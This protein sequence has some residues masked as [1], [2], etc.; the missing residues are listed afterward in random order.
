MNMLAWTSGLMIIVCLLGL[1]AAAEVVRRDQNQL[2]EW[3]FVSV[4]AHQDP[5]NQVQLDAIFTTPSGAELRVPGFWAGGK[6]WRVR[7]A[8]PEV[9]MHRFRTVWSDAA[10]AGLHGVEGA[11]EITKYTGDNPLYRRGP[12]RVSANKRYFE[13]ADGTP[14]FWLGDTWWLGL[15]K[16]LRFP[17]EFDILAKDRVA[18][19][20]TVVQIVAGLY[21]DMPAFDPRGQNEAGFPWEKDYARINPAYFDEADM[22]IERLVD[23]GLSP[24]IVGAWGFHLPWLGVEKMKRHWRYLIARWGAYPVFWCAAGEGMMP[25]Y[26]STERAK[27][28]ELQ[29]RGWTE[30]CA[31]I[32]ATDPYRRP[33][34]I[35][36]IDMARRQVADA[37]VLDF[38]ML[39]TGHS[40]RA[41]IAPTIQLLRESR[42]AKPTMPTLNSEV[43]YEG[44][45]GRH[46]E[47]IQ[48]IMA[49][50]SLLAGTAGHTYGGNGIWQVN[51]KGDEFGDSAQGFNWGTTPWDDAM[52]LP[53]STQVGHAKKL[54]E[55][56]ERWRFE[57]HPEWA[58][59]ETQPN[60]DDPPMA[61][62]QWIWHAADGD[63]KHEAPVGRR[64]F[65]RSFDLA[66]DAKVTSAIIRLSAD[67]RFTLIVNG[68][69]LATQTGWQRPR[70]FDIARLL[71]PGP[72]T[73]TIEAENVKSHVPNNPA[74]FIC[75]GEVTLE[76]S[77]RISLASDASW[78]SSES[79]DGD[80]KAA[81]VLAPYGAKPWGEL[82]AADPDVPPAAAGIPHQVRIIYLA[83][84]QPVRVANLD[85]SLDWQ[86]EWFDPIKGT[87]E[88][89]PKPVIAADGSCRIAPPAEAQDWVLILHRES[90]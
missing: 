73:I 13:H 49:W 32:R 59:W 42:A 19:G 51:R 11:V 43:C 57:P 65:R 40:D 54:L 84:P 48:R 53:G 60:A 70:K 77:P 86:A 79:P 69:K 34:S 80:F 25:W 44:L 21:P 7:Y 87:L 76:R 31:Y 16:R 83:E 45:L 50:T 78:L 28:M 66:R 55:R 2:A 67:D 74:G 3:S 64:W 37:S 10:D 27:E 58:A 29:K 35:H 22:R 38:E 5:F 75:A 12:I 18:K 46:D 23:S 56:F 90:P 30:L 14:F 89:L 15:S 33:I 82:A 17:D 71:K 9:G 4:I 24:C 68:Q 85:A 63:A 88:P 81:N 26:H 1:P 8:S 72:N 52:R 41:S 47:Q 61:S 62:G 39:Q 20:F 36:P 6:T